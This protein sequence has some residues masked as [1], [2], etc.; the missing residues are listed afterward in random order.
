MAAAEPGRG[1]PGGVTVVLALFG[2]Y[3]FRLF[4]MGRPPFGPDGF[5]RIGRSAAPGAGEPGLPSPATLSSAPFDRR[6]GPPWAP[7]VRSFGSPSAGSIG[8]G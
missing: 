5:L 2:G 6:P 8:S 7:A 4:W 3:F 1:G